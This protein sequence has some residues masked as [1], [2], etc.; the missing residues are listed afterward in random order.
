MTEEKPSEESI[1]LFVYQQGYAKT[2]TQIYIQFSGSM[3]YGQRKNLL[4]FGID[5][6]SNPGFYFT[7]FNI[8][9]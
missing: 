7:V 4:D 5:K 9:R 1:K 3:E 2:T 8:V 6:G